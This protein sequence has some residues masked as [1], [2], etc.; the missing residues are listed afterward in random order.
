MCDEAPTQLYNPSCATI[1]L[2]CRVTPCA[3]RSSNIEILSGGCSGERVLV[4]S[5]PRIVY[6][7]CKPKFD[8]IFDLAPGRASLFRL[9]VDA[10]TD[11]ILKVGDYAVYNSTDVTWT[12]YTES[13][14]STNNPNVSSLVY[15]YVHKQPSHLHDESISWLIR[16]LI[17]Y[18]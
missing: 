14:S 10:I 6:D 12:I 13:F 18:Y 16:L 7:T 3:S 11:S 1:P 9:A 8:I 4:E 5:K 2:R 15:K 17:C